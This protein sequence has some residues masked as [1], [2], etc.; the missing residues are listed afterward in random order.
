MRFQPGKRAEGLGAQL[1]RNYYGRQI[2]RFMVA[3]R[4]AADATAE[5]NPRADLYG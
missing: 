3:Q 5:E 2:Q 1:M 4:A